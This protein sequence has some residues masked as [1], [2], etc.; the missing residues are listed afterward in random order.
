MHR[1]SFIKNSSII[2][3]GAPI[4]NSIG[5]NDFAATFDNNNEEVVEIMVGKIK[6]TIFRD[7]V[8][9]YTASR[10]FSNADAQELKP[11][12][13]K[14]KIT[15][16]KI[17]SP[18]I[19]ML[20]Q[21]GNK[22]ILIDTG[23]GYLENPLVV[24]GNAIKFKGR[25]HKLMASQKFNAADINDVIITHFHPDHIGGIYSEANQLL[26]PNARFHMHEDEWSYWHSSKADNQSPVFKYIIEK[27]IS[28]LKDG[29]L[30]LIK[31]DFTEILPGL[32][33][34]KADGHT[35]R[36]IAIIM[37]S[38][39][40]HL[41]YISD[42]FLHPLHIERLDW[43]TNYDLDHAKAKATRIKLLDLAH[44]EDMLVNAFHFDFPGLGRAEKRNNSWMWNYTNA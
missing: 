23:M 37:H 30:N 35:P 27:N 43:Q 1:R 6:C 44:K 8:H 39:K 5:L 31:G 32:T 25:L 21:Y 2:A 4:L 38:Q 42:A 14:Y 16:D 19:A 7:H 3:C 12:L 20:L 11:A 36:Q 17:P 10:Y 41:L 29:N 24:N 34:V 26:F 9:T 33:A 22:K 15:P 40:D 18:F 13:E 28:P